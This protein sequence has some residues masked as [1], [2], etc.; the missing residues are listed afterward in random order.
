MGIGYTN[1]KIT[2]KNEVMTCVIVFIGTILLSLMIY[3]LFCKLSRGPSELNICYGLGF[4]FSAGFLFM[5]TFIIVG[6]LKNSFSLV[7]E[8]WV[9]F[10]QNLKISFG[11]AIESFFDHLKNEGMVFWLYMLLMG[12]QFQVA[13]H[14]LS[15]LVVYYLNYL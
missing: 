1:N 4:G 12:V 3:G 13:Y 8:R 6:G 15:I 7:V 14:Y 10:F 11:F 5:I 9:D 2:V